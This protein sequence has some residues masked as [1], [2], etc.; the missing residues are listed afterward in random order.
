MNKILYG[1]VV[2]ALVL[3]VIGIT[4]PKAIIDVNAIAKRVYDQINSSVGAIAGTEHSFRENFNAGLFTAGLN[5]KDGVVPV[6]GGATMTGTSSDICDN[7]VI[8]LRSRQAT[9]TVVTMPAATTFD[10]NGTCLSKEGDTKLFFLTN[11]VGTSTFLNGASTSLSSLGFTTSTIGASSTVPIWSTRFASG[12]Q[13][14]I[15]FLIFPFNP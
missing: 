14:W 10:S 6:W 7:T 8:R 13:Q 12:T 11:D 3:G 9:G 1:L 5:D 2:V 15:R 4:Y